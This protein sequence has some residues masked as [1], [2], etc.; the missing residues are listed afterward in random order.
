MATP[1]SKSQPLFVFSPIAAAPERRK[2]VFT[3]GAK[4]TLLILGG[5]SALTLTTTLLSIAYLR[6]SLS[7]G[8]QE[9]AASLGKVVGIAS[10]YQGFFDIDTRKLNQYIDSAAGQPDVSYAAILD[11]QGKIIVQRGLD[12]SEAMA[13][14]RGEIP[15]PDRE[16]HQ[17]KQ[18][19]VLDSPIGKIGAIVIGIS[20]ARINQ[21]EKKIISSQVGVAAATAVLSLVILWVFVLSITRPL[22]Q[23]SRQAALIEQGILDRPIQVKSRDEIGILAS[24]IESMRGS[25][26]A[27]I[28]RIAFL[29]K[30]SAGLTTAFSLEE[31]IIELRRHLKEFP[32][33]PWQEIGLALTGRGIPDHQFHYYRAHPILAREDKKFNYFPL[34][35]TVIGETIVKKKMLTRSGPSPASDHS[36]FFLSLKESA[37]VSDVSAPLAVKM[38]VL[39]ALYLGFRDNSAE[40]SELQELVQTL[41]HELSS[42]IEGIYL[43]EDLR[44]NLQQLKRAHQE[45]KSLDS[46]KTEFISSVSHELRTPLVSLTGYMYMMLEEKLG[47]I[48]DLQKEGLEVSAKSLSRLTGLIEKMLAFSSEQRAEKLD[49]TDFPIESAINH[50]LSMVKAH[51]ADK[52]IE[53]LSSAEKN[54]PLVRADEDKIIQAL[55]NLVDN[56]IKYSPAGT[57]VEVKARRPFTQTPDREGRIEVLV[58]DRGRGIP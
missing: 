55:I 32:L 15:L 1:D 41:A 10:A 13:L 22:K 25:L 5:I 24:G 26:D 28:K 44:F 39:G 18:D 11:N 56:A 47:P 36:D 33:W 8:L 16:I 37:I 48:T 43:V 27:N 29:G 23:L 30:I 9:M 12:A 54:L 3:L 17:E 51:A 20:T 45:L 19:I 2:A 7:L 6:S 53:I 40:R 21:E 35:H 14:E 38:K 34:A 49:L 46:L 31:V 52:T 42:V 4:F 58:R 57:R 50:V